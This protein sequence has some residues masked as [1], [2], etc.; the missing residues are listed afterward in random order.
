MPRTVSR[1]VRTSSTSSRKLAKSLKSN[2]FRRRLRAIVPLLLA[3][4]IGFG[5]GTAKLTLEKKQLD[6][7]TEDC[8]AIIDKI[9]KMAE[10]L[11]ESDK[12]YIEKKLPVLKKFHKYL[13]QKIKELDKPKNTLK[14]SVRDLKRQAYELKAFIKYS[15]SLLE[16]SA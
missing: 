2:R 6:Q 1:T 5:L 4:M 7:R 13:E 12:A 15:E 16:P 9:S 10:P 3:S 11:K 8:Y 14:F